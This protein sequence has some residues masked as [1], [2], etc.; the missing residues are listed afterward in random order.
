MCVGEICGD[1]RF[2]VIKRAKEHL[3]KSTNIDSSE[4]EIKVLDNFLFRCW[5]MGW[6]KQY[7]E[8]ATDWKALKDH[9]YPRPIEG[10]PVS[11]FVF[12]SSTI[13]YVDIE[14]CRYASA[15]QY[16]YSKNQWLNRDGKIVI[17]VTH[18]MP[19]VLPEEKV[20]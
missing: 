11:E 4:D 1:S 20:I 17:G 12:V 19:I 3:L 5:Q 15:A 10:Y 18:W 8:T 13:N 7:D 6:L 2:E 9:G 16:D 14:I